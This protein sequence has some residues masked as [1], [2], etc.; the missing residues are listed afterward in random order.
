MTLAI[1]LL[2]GAFAGIPPWL[3]RPEDRISLRFSEGCIRERQ[4]AFR[5]YV[6]KGWI[7]IDGRRN[8][9]LFF[10]SE[11][12]QTYILLM[13]PENRIPMYRREIERSGWEYPA[14][15]ETLDAASAEFRRLWDELAEEKR[16]SRGQ[17]RMDERIIALCRARAS[18]LETMRNEFGGLEFDAFLYTTMTPGT[19]FVSNPQTLDAKALMRMETGCE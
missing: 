5:G 6:A 3:W 8:P 7:V 19:R 16:R 18:A 1:L 9:E 4:A 13:K 11:L 10:P 17:A 15:N 2:S 12:M 14:F